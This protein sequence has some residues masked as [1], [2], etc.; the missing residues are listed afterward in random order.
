[1]QTEV[2]Y[3]VHRTNDFVWHCMDRRFQ[4]MFNNWIEEH[5]SDWP[6]R[7]AWPGVSGPFNLG[8]TQETMLDAVAAAVQIGNIKAVHLINHC[9]CGGHGGSA[10]YENLAAERAYHVADLQQAAT[11]ITKH[12]PALEVHLYFADFDGIEEISSSEL[13]FSLSM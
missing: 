3:S 2:Q 1:M 13:T 9:D 7:V 10:Q 12:F 11:V 5:F 8:K 6:Y 4:R